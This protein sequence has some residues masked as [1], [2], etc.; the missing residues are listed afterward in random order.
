MWTPHPTPAGRVLVLVSS[1]P[2]EPESHPT[3]LGS[4]QPVSPPPPPT[5]QE[6]GLLDI[7]SPATR[8]ALSTGSCHHGPRP[9]PE[10]VPSQVLSLGCPSSRFLSGAQSASG[11]SSPE[12]AAPPTWLPNECL[13]WN[14]RRDGRAHLASEVSALLLQGLGMRRRSSEST[15]IPSS[16]RARVNPLPFIHHPLGEPCSPR[17]LGLTWLGAVPGPESWGDGAR[18][19]RLKQG[20][21][22]AQIQ[23]GRTDRLTKS[24]HGRAGLTWLL[25]FP[26]P[27][28]A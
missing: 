7:P 11:P 28:K 19:L 20:L 18:G 26:A 9:L 22:G 17:A 27:S 24:G 21:K 2:V 1:L 10:P 4:P 25:G 14:P 16:I 15:R 5:S 6:G 8:F 12:C 23:R 13:R 3:C